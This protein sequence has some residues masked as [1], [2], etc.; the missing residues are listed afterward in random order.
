MDKAQCAGAI[1][2]KADIINDLSV[3]LARSAANS[4]LRRAPKVDDGGGALIQR[5]LALMDVESSNCQ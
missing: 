2:V 3:M 1:S 4:V 5:I